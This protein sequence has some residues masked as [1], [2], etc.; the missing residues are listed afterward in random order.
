MTFGERRGKA[1]PTA[2]RMV[3][4]EPLWE[5]GIRT[6]PIMMVDHLMN[7]DQFS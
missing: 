7:R 2:R 3:L 4:L 1:P 6:L 5:A